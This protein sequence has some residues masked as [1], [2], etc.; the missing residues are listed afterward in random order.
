MFVQITQHLLNKIRG[1]FLEGLMECI[2][3]VPVSS[4]TTIVTRDSLKCYGPV[5]P[6][7]VSGVGRHE[8]RATREGGPCK[9][10]YAY[11]Q[12]YGVPFWDPP[13]KRMSRV[14]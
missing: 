1:T 5:S 14:A 2:L 12:Q 4:K 8:H 9:M 3:G 6:A 10:Q 11:F 7:D 13:M